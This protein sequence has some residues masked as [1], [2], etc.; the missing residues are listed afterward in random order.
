[1]KTNRIITAVLAFLLAFTLGVSNAIASTGQDLCP[2]YPGD[3]VGS[4]Q[5]QGHDFGKGRII[6][7]LDISW[8]A[9]ANTYNVDVWFN[10]ENWNIAKIAGLTFMGRTPVPPPYKLGLGGLSKNFNIADMPIGELIGPNMYRFKVEPND[11]FVTLN[12]PVY[13][14]DAKGNWRSEPYAWGWAYYDDLAP[15]NPLPVFVN[16]KSVD[17]HVSGANAGYGKI[18]FGAGGNIEYK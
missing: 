4:M 16:G 2:N 10:V 8:D 13:V 11:T 1:M 9:T 3:T 12:M 6:D 7:P 15:S 14:T 17:I 5:V 18:K